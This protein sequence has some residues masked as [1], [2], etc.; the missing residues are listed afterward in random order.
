MG[1]CGWGYCLYRICF[2]IH[3]FNYGVPLVAEAMQWSQKC[4][5]VSPSYAMEISGED[6][7]SPHLNKFHGVINGIDQDIWDPQVR[8]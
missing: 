2:S 3:N 6:A 8:F 4:T 1:L 5:T 7:I